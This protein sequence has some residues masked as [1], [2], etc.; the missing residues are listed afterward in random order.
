MISNVNGAVVTALSLSFGQDLQVIYSMSPYDCCTSCIGT[1]GCSGTL[2][3]R[4]S[5]GQCTLLMQAPGK[6]SVSALGAQFWTAEGT[7][8]DSLVFSNGLCGRFY[9]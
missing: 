8:N 7:P 5:S 2:Y 1:S 6:C 9:V 4:T 3:V